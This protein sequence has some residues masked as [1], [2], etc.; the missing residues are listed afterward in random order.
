MNC[1]TE[2]QFD[3][4]DLNLYSWWVSGPLE[5][6]DDNWTG[7]SPGV[8]CS[9]LDTECVFKV[10]LDDPLPPHPPRPAFCLCHL[11][12]PPVANRNQRWGLPLR[13]SGFS[14]AL[15]AGGGGHS[16]GGIKVDKLPPPISERSSTPLRPLLNSHQNCEKWTNPTSSSLSAC[17]TPQ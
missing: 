10:L 15:P 5:T 9:S 3:F 14:C 4:S 7:H 1:Q 17:S 8:T 16:A 2:K 6:W 11:A 13:L 12:P